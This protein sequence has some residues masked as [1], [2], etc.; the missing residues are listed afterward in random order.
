MQAFKCRTM[1]LDGMS[2]KVAR[3][4]IGQG[5]INACNHIAARSARQRLALKG[6]MS[7]DQADACARLGL[8]SYRHAH[9]RNQ[10]QPVTEQM[11]A[12]H[13]LQLTGAVRFALTAQQGR[14]SGAIVTN[15]YHLHPG[16]VTGQLG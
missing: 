6:P 13:G 14:S 5:S 9:K 2:A 15:A 7:Q 16:H 3:Y 1:R 11:L 4:G 8:D 10:F 12:T